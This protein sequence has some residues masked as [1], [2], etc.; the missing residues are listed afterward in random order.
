M[1]KRVVL[2]LLLFLTI[3]PFVLAANE[4]GYEKA[5]V[6]LETQLGEDCAASAS[7][8][9]TAFSLLAIAY[10]SGLQ[11]D[12]KK[13]LEDKEKEN[14][15]GKTSSD[16]CDIKSTSQAI[17]ALNHIGKN[18][19]DYIKWLED[20]KKQTTGLTWFL[21]IDANEATSCK[22]TTNDAN[23][24]TFTVNE[25]K[26][27]SGTSTC[28]APAENNYFL[29]IADS[30]LTSNFT[31]SCDKDFITTLLYKKTSGSTYYVSSLTNE[32]MAGD[33]TTEKVNAY[34]FG[35][36]ACDYEGSLWATIALAKLGK[37][38]SPYLP[39]LSSMYDEAD[40]QKYFPSAFLY[41]LTNEDDYQAEITGKQKQGKY[42]DEAGNKFYDTALA[43]LALQNVLIDEV[44]NSK[45]YL[46]TIQD[47]SGCWHSN[48]V[49]DTAFILYAAW[50]KTPAISG[51]IDGGRS[52]C[53]DF[54][55]YCVASE[56][57]SAEDTLTNF[58]CSGLS[59]ICCAVE[60]VEL[61]CEDKEGIVC[62]SGEK[63]TGS[64][65]T[66]SDTNYCCMDSC[67]E[68]EP[69]NPCEPTYTCKTSCS[70]G[71]TEKFGY[72]CDIGNACC[73]EKKGG[74]SWWLIILLIIL[75]ILVVLAIIFR[76]QL[77][78]WWF[79]TKS[80]LKLSKPPA[81]PSGRPPMNPPGFSQMMM[82]RPRQII[83]RANI[84][85]RRPMM[86]PQPQAKR[87]EKD[88]AF[89]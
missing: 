81:G 59:D 69:A 37:D 71:E 66:A 74:G 40:N 58:Y 44:S 22:I 76:N 65:I 39:Y 68:V 26:K 17:L 51:D 42:W 79:R 83:P 27:I 57:C 61:S 73:E 89:E 86:R 43:L 88:N 23:E 75:I 87:A 34:C 80:G 15:W 77:K 56:E 5:Y 72:D 10:N 13:A 36:N 20:K 31:I 78:I 1:K 63:C 38:I 14:C 24:K 8:E 82:P 32:A 47:A 6:C 33:S 55:H 3:I 50:P 45:D 62:S 7:T 46:L 60:P 67:Q 21:E 52:L 70:S 18:V 85:V 48:S 30:C 28:L 19:D 35:V 53:A 49:R 9:Q 11:G 29:R 16:S 25:N 41:M 84:P 12:C 2:I 64:E 4:T 54:N